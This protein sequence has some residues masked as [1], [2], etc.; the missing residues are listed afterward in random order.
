MSEVLGRVLTGFPLI[1]IL[2]GLLPANAVTVGE[3]LIAAGFR[4]IEVPLNS[5]QPLESIERLAGSC[6]EGVVVGAGTVLHRGEVERVKNAGGRLIVMPHGDASIVAEAKR[7]GMMCI[8]GVA[9]PTEGFSALAAGADAL[10]MFPAEAMPPAV[11]KAWRAVFP[12]E[13]LLIPVGG[14]TPGKLPDYL[15]AGANGLGLGSALFAPT[16]PADEL[17]VRARAFADS[18]HGNS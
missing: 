9:T 13:T 17:R 3:I 14:I 5:P 1:A 16:L 7:L 10:K 2:R 12:P 6:G 15:A 18:L 11:V 4:T 8:P